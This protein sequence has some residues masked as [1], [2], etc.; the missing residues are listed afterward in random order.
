MPERVE[1]LKPDEAL[2]FALKIKLAAKKALREDEYKRRRRE[3]SA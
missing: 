1:Y 2:V 3:R